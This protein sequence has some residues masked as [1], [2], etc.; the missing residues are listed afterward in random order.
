MRT[1]ASPVVQ[2]SLTLHLPSALVDLFNYLFLGEELS[3]RGQGA[4]TEL[5]TTLRTL[6]E[7]PATR[8]AIA[9]RIQDHENSFRCEQMSTGRFYKIA[10]C[11]E[12]VQAATA[13]ADVPSRYGHILVIRPDVIYFA[14][15]A[16]PLPSC[17]PS[18]ADVQK[19][20]GAVGGAIEGA[21][22]IAAASTAPSES[23]ISYSGEVLLTPARNLHVLASLEH[24]RCC[25]VS[26][27][28]PRGCFNKNLVAPWMQFL[29]RQHFVH[30]G[31]LWLQAGAQARKPVGGT[32]AAAAAAGA[33][34]NARRYCHNW[35]HAILRPSDP[36]REIA[37]PAGVTSWQNLTN[38]HGVYRTSVATADAPPSWT[39]DE[40]IDRSSGQPIPRAGM[41]R[42]LLNNLG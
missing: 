33:A 39:I 10:R 8:R 18:T 36:T 11:A 29:F 9:T 6:R 13:P 5:A 42:G 32:S 24:V 34:S 3:G 19:V 37:M 1:F 20:L 16:L 25:N 30:H 17:L 26:A 23:W 41:R 22:A 35:P 2:E 12:M 14:P 7:L 4:E 27:R 38:Q 40:L 15:F 28:K 21:S 31:L